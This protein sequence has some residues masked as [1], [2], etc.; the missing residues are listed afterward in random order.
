MDF[1]N[2]LYALSGLLVGF[3]I[4][5]TGVGGGSLMTP[6]MVLA[7]GMHP[8]SAVGTDLV[9]ASLTK[10]AGTGVHSWRHT[11][12]WKIVGR[13]AM[14]SVP[15]SALTLL[16]LWK[17]GAGIDARHGLVTNVLGVALIVTAVCIFFRR[18]IVEF[19]ARRG[20]RLEPGRAAWMTIVLGAAM[21][22][23][24]S[25]SSVGA[26]AIGVTVLMILYPRMP[27]NRL[28]GSDIAHAVP[29]TLVAGL[30][31]W[32]MGTV[33][34]SMLLSLL[35]GSIPGIIVGSLLSSRAPDRVLQPILASTLAIVGGRLIF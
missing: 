22:V 2:P 21:G 34:T 13:L 11:V 17:W 6:I 23:L 16:A 28:V 30:G 31:H 32:M 35:V 5:L 3:L 7:F 24:V 14:G 27:V 10:T 20:V 9:Y 4:G 33:N 8:S 29:L 26:G 25:V 19:I 1:I 18:H 12:D 15:A